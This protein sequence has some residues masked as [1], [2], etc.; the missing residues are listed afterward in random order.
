LGYHLDPHVSACALLQPDACTQS[1]RTPRQ[2]YDH[3]MVQANQVEEYRG[4]NI[5]TAPS[6]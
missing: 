4:K 6:G 1:G 3:S 5:V 2:H